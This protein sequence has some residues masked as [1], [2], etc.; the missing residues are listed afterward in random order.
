MLGAAP[1]SA[2]RGSISRERVG[3]PVARVRDFGQKWALQRRDAARAAR[4][5]PN[6][7]RGRGPRE[8]YQL[9]GREPPIRPHAARPR[10]RGHQ[11]RGGV[12]LRRRSAPGFERPVFDDS[13][14]G[15]VKVPAHWEM[16]GFRSPSGIGGYRWHCKAP[17]GPAPF[18]CVSTGSTAARRSSATGSQS[19][20][21]RGSS[22]LRGRP[23]PPPRRRR[24][25]LALKVFEHTPTSEKLDKMSAYADVPL[26]G[27]FRKV[28]MFRVPEAHVA[29]L[30]IA[31][32]FDPNY[33]NAAVEGSVSI[34][35]ESAAPLA[36]A[37]L[38]ARLA[39]AAGREVAA[40]TTNLAAPPGRGPRCRSRSRSR[41]R[42][43]GTPSSPI[44]TSS[45]S[46]SPPRGAKRKRSRSASASAKPRSRDRR[47]SSMGAP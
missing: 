47:S 13:A 18:C 25:L 5:R 44:F 6:P 23:R 10:R 31:T 19:P 3:G 22:P 7:H 1:R 9:S 41:R 11:S 20:T 14:W 4:P 42:S 28:T 21:T 32:R 12:A 16:E 2:T 15:Q 39:D 45:R 24:S 34:V 8:R 35:N 46:S 17:P 36:G 30:A 43:P 27:I 38:R 26:G 33:R 37:T 29:A 40:N